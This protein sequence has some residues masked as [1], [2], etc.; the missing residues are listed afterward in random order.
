MG[1]ATAAVTPAWSLADDP[2]WPGNATLFGLTLAVGLVAVSLVG[3]PGL[4]GA[5]LHRRPCRPARQ[6]PGRAGEP[7]PG[8]PPR[9]G[10][11]APAARRLRDLRPTRSRPRRREPPPGT[12]L[13][14]MEFTGHADAGHSGTRSTQPM[15]LEL[16]DRARVRAA[17]P[18]ELLHVTRS[19]FAEPT[20]SQQ[21][22]AQLGAE[23]HG[24]R[25][26]AARGDRPARPAGPGLGQLRRTRGRRPAPHGLPGARTCW[27]AWTADASPTYII[28]LYERGADLVVTDEGVRHAAAAATSLLRR[29]SRFTGNVQPT[30]SP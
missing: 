29:R 26:A 27:S 25:G 11:R 2:R 12:A 14:H 10:D 1:L 4:G 30:G 22:G 8:H 20:L 17:H 13:T 3:E 7:G 15:T 5:V 19:F 24:P 16:A 9:L 23:V 21:V 18:F 28:D 6:R